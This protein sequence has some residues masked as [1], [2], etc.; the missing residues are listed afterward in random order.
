MTLELNGVWTLL[1]ALIT[2]EFGRNLNRWLPFLERASIP[3]AVS[4][5]LLVSIALAGLRAVRPLDLRFATAPGDTLLL[6]FFATLG[7]GAHLGRLASAGKGAL[8]ICFAITLAILVQNVVGITIAR[9]VGAPP[10]AGLFVGSMAFMGGHGT[11][12]AWA[13]MPEAE[14]IRGAFECGIGSATLGLVLGSLVAGPVA[15]WIASRSALVSGDGAVVEVEQ[16]PPDTV[17]E[18][19]FASHR[20]LRCLLWIMGCLAIGPWIR[21]LTAEC[22][23]KMPTFLGVLLAGVVVTNV[24]DL[25]RRPLDTEASE[26]VGTLALHIFLATAMLTLD[27]GALAGVLAILLTGAIAQ[28]IVT[29]LIGVLVVYTL[30][31]RDREA[32]VACGGFIA[33]SLAAM[34]VSIAVMRRLN[35]RL[36]ETPRAILAVVM[37]GA[38]YSHTAN[39]LVITALFD[40]LT[41]G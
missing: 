41:G 19:P 40:R 29:V 1:A 34:P 4:G 25:R 21:D 31:G 24:A 32:I 9:L 39:A 28:V 2:I 10:A 35:R 16:A 17:H 6:I 27:W 30:F 5:G 33:F 3:A 23:F 11:V 18:N 12:T 22:G 38:L 13:K 20:W 36:G 15:G 7:F 37:S 26:L 8:I 14:N